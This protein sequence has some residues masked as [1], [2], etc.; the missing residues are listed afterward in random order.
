VPSGDIP[1]KR[2][3]G[4]PRQDWIIA[5][6]AGVA[7]VLLLVIVVLALC[8]FE[9]RKKARGGKKISTKMPT[10]NWLDAKKNIV[11]VVD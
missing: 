11:Y 5:V 7:G 4:E 10:L 9:R 1:R 8:C 6:I 3:V 2:E